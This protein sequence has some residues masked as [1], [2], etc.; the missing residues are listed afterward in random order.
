[1]KGRVDGGGGGGCSWLPGP[2]VAEQSKS[3]YAI[4]ARSPASPLTPTLSYTERYSSLATG[5]GI[6]C[7]VIH[8]CGEELSVTLKEKCPLVYPPSPL[9]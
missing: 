7:S 1:M 8:T 4:D 3:K 6:H 2:S 9:S 5:S